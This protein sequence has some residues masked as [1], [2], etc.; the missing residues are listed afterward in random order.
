[1]GTFWFEVG[2]G[3]VW[4]LAL[5]LGVATGGAAFFALRYILVED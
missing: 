5:G 3:I 4:I 2:V 1:M